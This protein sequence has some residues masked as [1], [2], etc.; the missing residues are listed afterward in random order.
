[1]PAI[2]SATLADGLTDT[3]IIYDAASGHWFG[4]SAEFVPTAAFG[5]LVLLAR[6]DSSNPAGTWKAVSFVANSGFGDFDTL[7]VDSE[8]VY[9]SVN[10]FDVNNNLTGVSFFSIP[11]SDLLASTLNAESGPMA[12]SNDLDAN[13]YGFALQGVN[14]PDA[15]P[16]YGAILAIDNLT[17]KSVR[18]STTVHGPGSRGSNAFNSG[19]YLFRI[20]RHSQPASSTRW[21]DCGWRR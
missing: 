7:G 2:S 17:L 13:T 14:N 3:R 21:P 4:R 16:S 9:L 10:D 19:G 8:G 18:R 11:K 20:R 6:S 15:G 1:M 12:A 5:N